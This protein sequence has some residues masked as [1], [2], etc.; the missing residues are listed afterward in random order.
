MWLTSTQ[1]SCCG[2]YQKHLKR[3]FL[4][5]W[6]QLSKVAFILKA[7]AWHDDNFTKH[8]PCTSCSELAANPIPATFIFFY[9]L[10]AT[11]KTVPPACKLASLETHLY[12]L[13][14]NINHCQGRHAFPVALWLFLVICG[15]SL[16]SH[17][18]MPGQ[19][20]RECFRT[21]QPPPCTHRARAEWLDKSEQITSRVPISQPFI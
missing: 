11:V 12:E 5:H 20:P 10:H 8:L 14:P 4:Y 3:I 2:S 6:N 13:L 18:E 17:P 19:K 1:I 7:T 15:E 16:Q 21:L 9:E